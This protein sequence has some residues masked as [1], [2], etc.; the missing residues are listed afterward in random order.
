MCEN[1]RRHRTPLLLSQ[2]GNICL[3][4]VLS[5]TFGVKVTVLISV[6]V[7][8]PY[9]QHKYKTVWNSSILVCMCL[10][11]FVWE[12]QSKHWRGKREWKGKHSHTWKPRIAWLPA[13]SKNQRLGLAHAFKYNIYLFAAHFQTPLRVGH[14]WRIRKKRARRKHRLAS[15]TFKGLRALELRPVEY[16]MP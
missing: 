11:V 16:L 6:D 10:C 12:F 15:K 13:L 9:R 2:Q 7:F 3:K 4:F 5:C 1:Q 14:L 8:F